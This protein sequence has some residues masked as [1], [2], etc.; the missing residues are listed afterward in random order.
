MADQVGVRIGAL[1]PLSRPGWT[2]AGRHLLAGLQFGVDDVNRTGGIAGQT[3]ELVVQDNSGDPQ[4]AASAV[5]ELVALDVIAVVGEYHSVVARA[6]A[7]R[8]AEIGM[9]FLC[10]SAVLDTLTERPTNWVARIAPA[11]S[12]GWRIYAEFLLDQGHRQI[13]V[14]AQTSE[15]WASG[16][17]IL[18]D[19]I[20]ARGG[21]VTEIGIAAFATPELGNALTENGCSAL[22]L[23]LAYPE[24]AVSVVTAVRSD[25]RLND[26]MVGAPAGQPE[27]PSWFESL[28][29][30]GAAIPFLRYLPDRFDLL[31]EVVHDTLRHRLAETPSFVAFEGYD[32]IVVLAEML[33]RYG[34]DRTR[35][36]EALPLVK[37][38]G[39][40]GTI[41]FSRLQGLNVWQWAWPPI[42][43]VDRDPADPNRFRILRASSTAS[44]PTL[45]E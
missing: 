38:Q 37:V 13:A 35:F 11:Q 22:L 7:N 12:Y 27:L 14:A 29:R 10:S 15:Y 26:V 43:I 34:L 23:L 17:Q 32:T 42:Q 4:K 21:S 20:A 31:G 9:P 40:R 6:A 1:V 8:C 41:R 2:D 36:A 24:P 28:G 3:I 18:R 19:C 25:P 30:Q 39:T 44:P 33:R 45:A 5:D 16:T